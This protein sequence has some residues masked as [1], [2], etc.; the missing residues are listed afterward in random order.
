MLLIIIL[1]NFNL[2]LLLSHCQQQANMG[3]SN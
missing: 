2:A 1:E 3:N